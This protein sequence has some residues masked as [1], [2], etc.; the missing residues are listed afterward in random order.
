[1]SFALFE[2]LDRNQDFSVS[3][4]EVAA[5]NLIC[6]QL[7]VPES[8]TAIGM[9]FQESGKARDSFDEQIRALFFSRSVC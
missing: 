3:L 9:T 8:F 6:Q 1:M 4:Q 7:P 2:T 5:L